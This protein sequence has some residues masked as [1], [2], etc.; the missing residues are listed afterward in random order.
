MNRAP[1]YDSKEVVI[2]REIKNYGVLTSSQSGSWRQRL[3]TELNSAICL[4]YLKP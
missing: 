4:R 1:G 2:G 3:K